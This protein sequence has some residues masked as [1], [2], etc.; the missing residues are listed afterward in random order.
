V[1]NLIKKVSFKHGWYY[2]YRVH[3]PKTAE[4]CESY[5][6]LC[7]YLEDMFENCP[8]EY[9]KLEPRSSKLKFK[10]NN[11]DLVPAD[12][13]EVCELT[14]QG[15]I[16]N[17][18]RFKGGHSKVQLFMLENDPNTIAIEV[19]LWLQPEEIEIYEK[20]FQSKNPLTGHIDLV[21]IEEDKIWIWDY[22]PNAS[23]EKYASTQVYFY[24]LMLSK[25][26]GIPLE[27]FRCG[28]FDSA[29]C[30]IFKP[31]ANHLEA[32]QMLITK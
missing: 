9:F 13:H 5:P 11:L 18:T 6:E 10:L 16:E 27:K 8:H 29:N 4:L 19:P 31:E 7:N 2:F 17:E 23:K 14:K 21:R 22:K 15:L 26:T 12:N 20:L 28:Y 25:R 24:A 32:N 3:E 30:Y 1:I